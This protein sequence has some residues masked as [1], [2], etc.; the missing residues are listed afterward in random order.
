MSGWILVSVLIGLIGVCFLLIVLA[1]HRNTRDRVRMLIKFNAVYGDLIQAQ[2]ELAVL[3]LRL[4]DLSART[5]QHRV[6][7][8]DIR[9]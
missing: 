4:D 8:R 5:P 2:D 9:P 6:N 1:E 3:R 7:G